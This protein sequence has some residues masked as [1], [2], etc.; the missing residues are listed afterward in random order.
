MA[1]MSRKRKTQLL[2]AFIWDMPIGKPKYRT[3][4]SVSDGWKTDYS[5]VFYV[6]TA[7]GS[8]ER[9]RR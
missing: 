7:D 1:K 8:V 4:P 2:K 3:T 5:G 6:T 9:I